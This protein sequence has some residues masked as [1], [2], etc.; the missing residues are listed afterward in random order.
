M[1]DNAASNAHAVGTAGMSPYGASYG[2][3]DPDLHV[4]GVTGLRIIDA[5]IVP[6]VPSAHTM[7]PTYIIAERGAEFVKE[8]WVNM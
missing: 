8:E 1:R 2:V 7:A 5:S 6:F 3:V 4:K